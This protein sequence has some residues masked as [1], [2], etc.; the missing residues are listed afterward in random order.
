MGLFVGGQHNI[1]GECKCATPCVRT[2]FE[3]T[4]SFAVFAESNIKQVALGYPPRKAYVKERFLNAMETQQRVVR[5]IKQKDTAYMNKLIET[6]NS[7]Q[8]SAKDM[9]E[10]TRN[11]TTF[12]QTYQVVDIL[13]ADF[14]HQEDVKA[15][16]KR[17]NGMVDT[18]NSIK[19]LA[20]ADLRINFQTLIDSLTD[21][22]V[23]DSGASQ[24][25][26]RCISNG[27]NG[28]ENYENICEQTSLD[29][30]TSLTQT[31]CSVKNISEIPG[32]VL[33]GGTEASLMAEALNILPDIQQY[34]DT[35]T[36]IFEDGFDPV[37]HSDH[38][39]CQ[40][41]L[42][43]YTDNVL[44]NF[45]DLFN[46][47]HTIENATSLI[48]A[49][50]LFAMLETIIKDTLGPFLLKRDPSNTWVSPSKRER[51][52][53]ICAW[54]ITSFDNESQRFERSLMKN[55][56]LYELHYAFILETFNQIVA[57]LSSITYLYDRGFEKPISL[58]SDYLDEQTTKEK[59]SEAIADP[60]MTVAVV[61]LKPI[62]GDIKTA[63]FNF[64]RAYVAFAESSQTLYSVLETRSWPF[65]TSSN[66]NKFEFLEQMLEWYN[67]FNG[68][69]LV[70]EH[71]ETYGQ[72]NGYAFPVS[73]TFTGVNIS[74]LIADAVKGFETTSSGG[75]TGFSAFIKDLKESVEAPMKSLEEQFHPI[76]ED[77][78]D[79]QNK[80]LMNEEFYA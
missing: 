1:D 49:E 52:E 35:V 56:A 20:F 71:L 15:I 31:Y 22:N 7:L 47:I 63:I 68:N 55:I 64:E 14:S 53:R 54:Y 5:S 4:L 61:S 40:N 46:I 43:Q 65:I 24:E 62:L 59:L 39:E 30:C 72:L 18:R 37:K 60:E 11:L 66:T 58:F 29:P 26:R 48:E 27:L 17:Q 44:P 57:I 3:P 79:Y 78:T 38:Y 10:S 70:R 32:L 69:E 45:T 28:T 80:L 77:M 76:I 42:K 23:I 25:I 13:S 75:Q 12:A 50:S 33:S 73:S 6:A 9:Y 74:S 19:P 67:Y 41:T 36:S 34:N 21:Y 16:H 51:R 2:I 8:L